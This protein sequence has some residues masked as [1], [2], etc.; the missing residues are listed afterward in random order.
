MVSGDF[1]WKHRITGELSA[2]EKERKSRVLERTKLRCSKKNDVCN[3]LAHI[4]I[5]KGDQREPTI[6]DDHYFKSC[7]PSWSALYIG[8]LMDK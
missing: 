1:G 4:L 3:H 8:D 5:I 6:V 7:P 2:P